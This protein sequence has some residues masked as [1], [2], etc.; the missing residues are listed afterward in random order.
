[1]SPQPGSELV[2]CEIPDDCPMGPAPHPF[3]P[4]DADF[5]C[6]CRQPWE[7]ARERLIA[8]IADLLARGQVPRSMPGPSTFPMSKA[9]Y[10]AVRRAAGLFGWQDA[11]HIA[12]QLRAV[13]R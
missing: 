2:M 12:G 6:C 7:E 11:D 8:A 9:D 1:M 4:P 3:I 5:R 13:L 10:D